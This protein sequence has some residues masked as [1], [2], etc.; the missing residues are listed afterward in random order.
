MIKRIIFDLDKTLIPFPK[1]FKQGYKEVLEEFNLSIKPMDLYNLIGEYEPLYDH[2]DYNLL[3]NFINE[4]LNTNFDKTFLDTFMNIYDNLDME[5]NEGVEETLE[6]L[7][8]KYS[9]VILS[10]WFTKSQ[11]NRMKKVCILKYFDKVYG[12]EYKSKPYKEAFINAMGDYKVEECIMV[13]DNIEMDIIP[14]EKLGI[15]TYYLGKSDKY[16]T[17]NKISDLKEKL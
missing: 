15:K 3:L 12:G 16:N 5:L 13:G 2:Y 6:Y 10:N 11:E 8:K 9:L 4:R 7:S 1:N 17:I 14:A